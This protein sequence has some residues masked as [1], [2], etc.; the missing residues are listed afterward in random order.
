MARGG[1]PGSGGGGGT[2]KTTIKGTREDDRIVIGESPHDGYSDAT[3][4][5]GFVIDGWAGN[6]FLAGG[7]GADRLI[8]GA[9]N[10]W[11]V[12]AIDDLQGVPSGT[13]IYDGGHGNDTIDF[14]NVTENIGVDLFVD[15]DRVLLGLQIETTGG[16]DRDISWASSHAGALSGIENVIGGSGDDWI[17]GDWRDNRLEG[18]AGDDYLE[19]FDGD[20]VLI[21][22]EGNDLLSAGWGDNVLTGGSG[23]DVFAITG[24]VVGQYVHN[25]VTDFDTYSGEGDPSF[26]QIWLWEGW[27]VQWIESS[28]G[29]L[30]GYLLDG[31]TIFGEITID[32]LT[33]ADRGLVPVYAVDSA[34]G[35]PMTSAG[36]AA[37]DYL[38]G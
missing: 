24:R 22:G 19:G 27:S 5:N 26:D 38:I 7:S 11:L 20:D 2:A 18:G 4:A 37:G 34:T 31:S 29:P 35:D 23:S 32:N 30:R 13:L 33:Y 17:R 25:V 6:D 21:G 8:G 10:D 12:G 28:S 9:G 36:Y 16:L 14:S 3:I 15:S 1:K